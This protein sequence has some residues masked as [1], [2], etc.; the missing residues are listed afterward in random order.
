MPRDLRLNC[1]AFI[2]F[3]THSSRQIQ[4]L[5]TPVKIYLHILKTEKNREI[6]IVISLD[7]YI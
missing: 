2:Y 7:K 3:V 1:F 5:V 4:K 6:S